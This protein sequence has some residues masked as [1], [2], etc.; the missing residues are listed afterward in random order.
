MNALVNEDTI[1]SN[2]VLGPV[3]C[4]AIVCTNAWLLFTG[5]LEDRQCNLNQTLTISTQENGFE[6]IVY[7]MALI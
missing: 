1:V 2:S 3:W 5:S 7:K 4:E 6:G